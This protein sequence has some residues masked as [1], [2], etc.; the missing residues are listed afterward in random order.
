MGKRGANISA[1]RTEA[2]RE[3]K[4][5]YFTGKPCKYGHV[6]ERYTLSGGCRE[7]KRLHDLT[8]NPPTKRGPYKPR[9]NA[10]PM[11]DRGLPQPLSFVALM[12][13]WG[14]VLTPRV[15]DLP[16]RIHA[17]WNAPEEKAAI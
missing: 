9:G 12:Q 17:L 11:E 13:A 14:L 16:A 3:G 5:F 6:A 15:I 1:E 8:H 4:S 7:C 2:K 10:V